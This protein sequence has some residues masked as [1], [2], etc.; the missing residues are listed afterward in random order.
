MNHHTVT[1]ERKMKTYA[2]LQGSNLQEFAQVAHGYLPTSPIGC[3]QRLHNARIQDSFL[4]VV[5]IVVHNVP[6]ERVFPKELKFVFEVLGQPYRC[7]SGVVV[8][9]SKKG[10]DEFRVVHVGAAQ[11]GSLFVG[12]FAP[13]S[14]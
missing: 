12:L 9:C 2:V 5:Q 4:V 3:G 8:V 13:E 6:N 11:K 10:Q 7:R 14:F 1:T